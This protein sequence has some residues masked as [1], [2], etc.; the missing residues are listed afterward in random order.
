LAYLEFLGIAHL[1]ITPR[2]F[3]ITSVSTTTNSPK[4]PHQPHQFYPR[5]KKH[6]IRPE[7]IRLNSEITKLKR[8]KLEEMI[9]NKLE[10]NVGILGVKRHEGGEGEERR[11]LPR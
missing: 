2:N 8:P 1:D 6:I 3:V 7:M 11:E 10:K 5:L 9:S 4:I